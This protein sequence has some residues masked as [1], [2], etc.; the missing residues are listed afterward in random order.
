[1]AKKYMVCSRCYGQNVKADAYAGWNVETQ[2]WEIDQ[3]FDKGAYCD[4]CDGECRIEAVDEDEMMACHE[5]NKLTH[6]NALD[7]KRPEGADENADATILL[8]KSC[9]GEGYSII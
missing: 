9:Y 4:D 6:P 7:A 3:T 8:C 5:C 1:M 2:Q